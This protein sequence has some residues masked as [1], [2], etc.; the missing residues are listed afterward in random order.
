MLL[1]L[2]AT[3]NCSFAAIGVLMAILNS[4]YRAKHRDLGI[5]YLYKGMFGIGIPSL[6]RVQR[7]I[8]S[9]ARTDR[10]N[11]TDWTDRKLT[12]KVKSTTP[13]QCVA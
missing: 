1:T 4:R 13:V 10:P 5:P 11:R 12:V 6:N 8:R 7:G 9:K 3:F 2:P